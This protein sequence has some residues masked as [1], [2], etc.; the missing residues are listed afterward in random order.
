M[1]GGP[2]DCYLI[3]G[4]AGSVLWFAARSVHPVFFASVVG[5]AVSNPSGFFDVACFII[6]HISVGFVGRT[7]MKSVVLLLLTSSV[8]AAV[9]QA[10]PGTPLLDER[11]KS[12]RLSELVLNKLE[13]RNIGPAIMGGR[14][15]DFAV[16]ESD[17]R[18]IYTATASG[19]LWKTTNNAVTWESIFDD[20][21]VSSIG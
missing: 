10:S 17:P 1:V 7:R 21:P 15:D 19:G 9:V 11:D 5:L 14:I 18:I 16:V 6:G 3:A 12:Q 8:L 2:V 13:W 4:L 20:Q